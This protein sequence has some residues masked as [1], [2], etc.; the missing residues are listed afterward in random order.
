MH[1]GGPSAGF[2]DLAILVL[3]AAE[4]SMFGREEER[5]AKSHSFGA[6]VMVVLLLLVLSVYTQSICGRQYVIACC[7]SVQKFSD[8]GVVSMRVLHVLRRRGGLLANR[9]SDALKIET[10]TVGNRPGVC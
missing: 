9:M 3:G 2:E 1:G 8:I 5:P 6:E 4:G 7:K 10:S